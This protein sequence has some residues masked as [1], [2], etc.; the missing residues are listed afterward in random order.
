MDWRDTLAGGVPVDPSPG[1]P[2]LRNDILDELGDHLSCA[3]QRELRRTDDEDAARS[4]VL[5][6]F[7]DPLLIAR[8]LWWG[9]VK[10]RVMR[11]R[12]LIGVTAVAVVI[13]IGAT[14]VAYQAVQRER[15]ERDVLMQQL[16][17]MKQSMSAMTSTRG[18]MKSEENGQS[19]DWAS[20]RVKIVQDTP[21][22]PAATGM[23]VWVKG[24]LFN[25]GEDTISGKV[26]DEGVVEL[27]PVRPGVV[28]IGASGGLLWMPGG[29]SLVLYPGTT[30]EFEIVRPVLDER[31][32]RVRP[33][34]KWPG[35]EPGNDCCLTLE[36]RSDQVEADG[37]TW[38]RNYPSDIYLDRSGKVMHMEGAVPSQ[39]AV[40]LGVLYAIG[41]ERSDAFELPAGTYSIRSIYGG[42]VTAH[43]SDPD[44]FWFEKARFS[45]TPVRSPFTVK[46]GE[47]MDLTIELQEDL[48]A[49]I[50]RLIDERRQRID[51]KNKDSSKDT[52][53]R[54]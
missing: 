18:V 48:N 26:N 21:E 42:I 7:G 49:S 43:A 35:K 36:V 31:V 46:P 52:R 19:S 51:Q 9:A 23:S 1:P 24:K 27:G 38:V 4:A 39:I 34:L 11:D 16:E 33:I 20:L 22:R 13:C 41:G 28:Q 37:I 14:L 8:E 53:L 15:L 17:T 10:E 2:E 30:R 32:G 45:G 54:S 29:K 3:M 12:I 47:D 6:R 5:E 40:G 50:E 44:K 25:E